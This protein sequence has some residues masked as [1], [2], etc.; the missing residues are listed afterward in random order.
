MSAEHMQF[1]TPLAL[2]FL[3]VLIFCTDSFYIH[4]NN[5]SG[6]MPEEI[7]PECLSTYECKAP[8]EFFAIDCDKVSC[9][10]ACCLTEDRCFPIPYG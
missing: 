10:V 5:L 3:T 8:I 6:K 4:G 1:A 2:A 7:C 9:P